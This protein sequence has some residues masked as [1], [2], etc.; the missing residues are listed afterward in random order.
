LSP[1]AAMQNQDEATPTRE[2]AAVRTALDGLR[3]DATKLGILADALLAREM[4]GTTDLSHLK[5]LA[6]AIADHTA[7]LV[8]AS[9]GV[10]DASDLQ[11]QPEQGA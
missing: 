9:Q 5:G 7:E 2:M 3:S 6:A 4:P 11:L 1:T 10:P 8:A